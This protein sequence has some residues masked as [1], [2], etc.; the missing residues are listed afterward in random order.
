MTTVGSP[1][2]GTS[3]ELGPRQAHVL[4]WMRASVKHPSRTWHRA[5]V[6]RDY[7]T[8][9]AIVHRCI[10]RLASLGVIAVQTVRGCRGETRFTFGVRRWKW[11]PPT[12][13]GVA[14]WRRVAALVAPGQVAF[15]HVEPEQ[16][17]PPRILA[18]HDVAPTRYEV[19]ARCGVT[20]EVR[21]GVYQAGGR[22]E[23]GLRC[24]VHEPCDERAAAR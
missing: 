4:A 6:M 13:R 20:G 1:G 9:T 23:S 11:T 5:P 2:W 12:R 22:Y 21:M 14:R 24:T 8:S 7:G 19:C 10:H 18:R 3:V 17:P 15:A 16:P